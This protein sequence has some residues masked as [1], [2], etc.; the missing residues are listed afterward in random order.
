MLKTLDGLQR[1]AA[2]FG[3]RP[4]FYVRSPG[5]INLIGEHIDYCGGLVMPMAIGQATHG[6]YGFNGTSSIRIFS[7]RFNELA[8][9]NPLDVMSGA[10]GH[11]SD[12]SQGLL[13][14]SAHRKL[15][16]GFDVYL[17]SDISAGGLSSSASL[18]ALL[19][20]VDHHALTGQIIPLADHSERLR[21]AMLCQRVENAYVGVPSGIMDPASVLLGEIMTLS[22]QTLK[23]QRL[24]PISHDYR[25]VIMDTQVPRTLAG[26]GYAARV[27]EV[28]AIEAVLNSAVPRGG[29][30]QC[31]PTERDD[32][33]LRLSD[34]V[35]KRRAQHIFDEQQRV[36]L[37]AEA[38]NRLDMAG[39]G[40]LMNQSHRSLSADYEVSC[41][42][43]DLVCELSVQ[44]GYSLGARMTG[45]GFGGC[46]ISLV[47]A[48][49]VE[50]HAEFVSAQYQLQ[51]GLKPVVQSCEPSVGTEITL[52]SEKS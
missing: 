40:A 42:E 27:A 52:L 11:W 22:C 48:K 20:M 16:R 19:S 24:A 5:R 14:F 17:T 25:L 35:L 4:D 45:A 43:L 18:L 32:H 21:L 2:S 23:Y 12:Y 34:P 26:S 1:F 44:S 3:Y 9:I 28:R 6:W 38:L 47:D 13:R 37:A 41:P 30:A 10:S 50:A 51:T 39:L 15:G 36:I 46:A 31:P 49:N 33:L 8:V 7:E 29:L